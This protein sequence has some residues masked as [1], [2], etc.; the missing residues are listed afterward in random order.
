M[1]DKIGARLRKLRTDRGETLRDVAKQIGI[2]GQALNYYENG[3]R[4]P[5]DSVKIKLAQYYG[6]TVGELFFAE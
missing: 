4:T 6:M 3:Q 2:S 1:S 5:R